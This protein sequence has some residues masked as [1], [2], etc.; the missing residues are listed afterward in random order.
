MPMNAEAPSSVEIVSGRMISGERLRM[1]SVMR[2]WAQLSEHLVA[3]I[4]ADSPARRH[5]SERECRVPLSP[6]WLTKQP[7]SVAAENG[8]GI[9]RGQARLMQSFQ[10]PG[11]AYKRKV[12]SK[13]DPVGARGDCGDLEN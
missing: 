12:A 10:R 8:V 5:S 6:A 11:L 7:Y 13:Q 1:E 4:W 9:F 2:R 3:H